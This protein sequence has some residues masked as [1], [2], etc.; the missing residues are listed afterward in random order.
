MVLVGTVVFFGSLLIGSCCGARGA[1]PDRAAL[2]TSVVTV[3]WGIAFVW[4]SI[5]VRHDDPVVGASRILSGVWILTGVFVV[6][7]ELASLGIDPTS[8]GVAT[9]FVMVATGLIWIAYPFRRLI[10]DR[11]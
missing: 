5:V 1:K 10:R 3:V 4:C 6:Y 2:Y 8:F 7:V 11:P 9:G